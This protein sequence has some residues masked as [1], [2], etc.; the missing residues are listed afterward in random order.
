MILDEQ[1]NPFKRI[2]CLYEVKRITDLQQDF[3]L[4]CSMGHVSGILECALDTPGK[5]K[6]ALEYVL[7]IEDALAE[8][9]AFNAGASSDDDKF[10][11]WHRI[12]DPRFRNVPLSTLRSKKVLSS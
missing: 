2:W 5:R 3:E 7:K 4:I 6:E 8:V 10:A 1:V 12:S 11:I 9:S